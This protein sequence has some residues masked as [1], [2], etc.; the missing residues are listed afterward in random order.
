MCGCMPVLGLQPRSSAG[1][2]SGTAPA[3]A[4]GQSRNVWP[5]SGTLT[6][7][8]LRAID[9]ARHPA[10]PVRI[11]DAFVRESAEVKAGAL[12]PLGKTGQTSRIA[13]KEPRFR[14]Q[15]AE[16]TNN[17]RGAASAT[18]IGCILGTFS[19]PMSVN[20]AVRRCESQMPNKG[21]STPSQID[22]TESIDP[23]STNR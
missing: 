3:E 20:H 5:R 19:S 11:S 6:W 8:A 16:G 1:C 2:T 22:R 13:G 21:P 12:R 17:L 14:L 9:C 7:G 18:S 4:A 23:R 15:A 10:P